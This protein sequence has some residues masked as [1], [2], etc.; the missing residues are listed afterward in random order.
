VERKK[1]HGSRK[2]TLMT[3]QL[4]K[5]TGSKEEKEVLYCH[6]PK[7]DRRRSQLDVDSMSL[8][9]VGRYVNRFT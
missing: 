6:V 8:N 5:G 9:L 1:I 7:E 2:K 3:W 4:S